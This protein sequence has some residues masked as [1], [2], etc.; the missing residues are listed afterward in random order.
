LQAL[1][2]GGARTPV[3]VVE[4]VMQ[5]FPNTGLTNAY[6]LTE[7][8]STIAI[9]GPDEHR[10]AFDDPDPAARARLS[11]AGRVLPTVEV[12]IRDDDVPVPAGEP[13][14]IFVRGEQVSGEYRGLGRMLDDEGWF[15]T[16]DRGWLDEEG[17]LFVEGR[18]DDTIIRG[19]ENVAP[20]EIEETLMAHPGVGACAVV[21][22]PDDEW[23]Q[24]IAA[25]VVPAG[26]SELDPEELRAFVRERLRSS[27][28]PDAGAS[29]GVFIARSQE[30]AA[31]SFTS[32]QSSAAHSSLE[33][34]AF[35]S[36]Q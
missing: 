4:R 32:N 33:M 13:G 19:G 29:F 27:K 16:R 6:G 36:A 35:R 5:L 21:G 18:S 23:G 12:E 8:S 2:Y 20:A 30:G 28:T 3:S 34:F 17:Y 1:S 15:P 31:S 26:G 14:E 7:T 22:V 25:A 24:R 11:S 9:L 10:A